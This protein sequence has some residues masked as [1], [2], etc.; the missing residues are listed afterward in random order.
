MYKLTY[1]VL[2]VYALL[3][4]DLLLNISDNLPFGKQP[5]SNT[6]RTINS[7]AFSI[8]LVQVVA[9]LCVVFNLALH[10]FEAAEELRLSAWQETTDS[11]FRRIAPMAPRTAL[12]LVLDKYWWSL[13]VGLLYLVLTVILQIVRTD[14]I[15]HPASS[16]RPSI[17]LTTR[18]TVSVLSPSE[19]SAT[20]ND[21]FG[22]DH[23]RLEPGE[24]LGSLEAGLLPAARETD[25]TEP[26]ESKSINFLPTLLLLIHKLVSTCYYVSFVVVYRINPRQMMSRILSTHQQQSEAKTSYV[27][28]SR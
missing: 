7:V 8:I 22:N 25:A 4:L 2:F 11:S 17:G 24:G 15:W 28:Q 9:I 1:N 19:T 21:L 14:P 5:A 12:K 23:F 20:S 3:I 16:P 10:L 26:G 18:L 6:R 13:F 27:S